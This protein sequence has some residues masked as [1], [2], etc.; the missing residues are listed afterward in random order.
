MDTGTFDF[1]I[2]SRYVFLTPEA[3]QVMREADVDATD[4]TPLAD[5]NE[6]GVL[7]DNGAADCT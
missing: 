1:P 4:L 5:F 2:R 7:M 3:M 6:T